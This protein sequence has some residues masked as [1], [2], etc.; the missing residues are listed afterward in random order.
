MIELR[1]WEYDYIDYVANKA[2]VMQFLEEKDPSKHLAYAKQLLDEYP[3]DI[4]SFGFVAASAI[5]SHDS[6]RSYNN[7][8]HSL[9]GAIRKKSISILNGPAMQCPLGYSF[10]DYKLASWVLFVTDIPTDL[11]L[12]LKFLQTHGD[13]DSSIESSFGLTIY[14]LNYRSWLLD[15]E[16][17]KMHLDFLVKELTEYPEDNQAAIER[18]LPFAEEVYWYDYLLA[19]ASGK[20]I[21]TRLAA[22]S[23]FC[24]LMDSSIE[25]V[26]QKALQLV[27]DFLKGQTTEVEPW[28]FFFKQ[29]K[30]SDLGVLE[31]RIL[32]HDEFDQLLLS[33]DDSQWPDLLKEHF[34]YLQNRLLS[35]DYYERKDP[36]QVKY[37]LDHLGRY[38]FGRNRELDIHMGYFQLLESLFSKEDEFLQ[39]KLKQAMPSWAKHYRRQNFCI[40][41]AEIL[42]IL[43]L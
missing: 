21:N 33:Q 23:I 22:R 9:W 34:F 36:V 28:S 14:E 32:A 26:S 42:E 37:I 29:L 4:F 8:L 19:I 27:R 15:E 43:E 11:K 3:N 10:Q 20:I 7:P 2:L 31:E 18:L 6:G 38:I 1:G 41:A 35:K 13:K 5:T 16:T 40:N 30:A 24:R 17:Q 25:A 12:C 39:Q